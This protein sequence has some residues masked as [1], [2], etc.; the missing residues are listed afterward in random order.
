MH[1]NMLPTISHHLVMV[2]TLITLINI[3]KS[4]CQNQQYV[5]CGEPFRCGG[6]NFAYP[7]WGGGGIRPI[8]CGHPGFELSCEDGSSSTSIAFLQFESVRYRV[9][10][11]DGSR[12]SLTV[13][14]DDLWN[15]ICPRFIYETAFNYT[16]FRYSSGFQNVTLHYGCTTPIP[17]LPRQPNQFDCAG[18]DTGASNSA[19]FYSTFGVNPTGCSRSI[20]VPVNQAAIPNLVDS[21]ALELTLREGFGIEWEAN[22]SACDEC[23]RSGG[24]CGHNSSTAA[25]VCFCSDQSYNLTC[26]NIR[27]DNGMDLFLFFSF[28]IIIFIIY[29]KYKNYASFVFL[30][31]PRK[32]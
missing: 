17:N 11:I 20:S 18:N 6:H 13:A 23:T 32:P 25:F 9:L 10:R 22:N 3:P 27:N 15:D 30:C 8:S 5:T 24:R 31:T 14:R 12:Q 2:I 29:K 28:F 7:F 4:F 19:G 16:N 26:G 21:T 1:Q